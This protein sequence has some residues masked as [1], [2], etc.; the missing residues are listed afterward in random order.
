MLVTGRSRVFIL[1]GI[2]A[3]FVLLLFVI[4]SNFPELDLEHQKDFKYPRSLDEAKRLGRVLL[5]YR[6]R[7]MFAIFFGVVVVYIMLQ[8]F[9]IPGSI[10]LTI[11]SGYLFNFFV[12]LLLV[13]T[14]SAV[15]A[16]V[17]YLFSY[18]FGREFV[19]RKFP[20]RVRQWQ[21]DIAKHQDDL[22]SYI[23]FLRVTPFLPNWFIN[24]ASPV[25][26]VP[27][28]HFFVGTFLGVAPP[29]FLYIQAGSTLEQMVHTNVAWDFHSL[30][31]LTFFAV[32]S[33]I[34]VFWKKY[35]AK[36]A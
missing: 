5:H 7:H 24:I 33:L 9:A 21:G 26:N 10:F 3:T 2:F 34:P 12:A 36:R 8:S 16:S 23:I 1:C 19:V 32:L 15:G 27:F 35:K 18:I 17:C 13:C 28:F 31:L 20:D 29:S 30:F 4:Y 22:L 11:L 25:L 6:D 14:C